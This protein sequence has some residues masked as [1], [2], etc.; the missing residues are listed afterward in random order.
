MANDKKMS[1]AQK[2]QNTPPPDGSQRIG[3]SGGGGQTPKPENDPGK[4][5]KSQASKG[6]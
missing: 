4:P 5:K 6:A 3:P 2:D 1:A